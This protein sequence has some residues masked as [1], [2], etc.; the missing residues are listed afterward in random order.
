M[1]TTLTDGIS[2]E[3]MAA[4]SALF[5]KDAPKEVLVYVEGIDDKPFWGNILQP[6]ERQ[7]NVRFSIQTPAKGKKFA[8]KQKGGLGV[9]LIICVDSDYDYLLQGATETSRKVNSSSYVFQTYAYSIENMQCYSGGLQTI[10][11]ALAES[12]ENVV[13]FEDLMEKY[14]GIIY[15]LFLWS[16]YFYKKET[17]DFFPISQ[18]HEAIQV[19]IK[20]SS[21]SLAAQLTD[22]L[23]KLE[24][25]VKKKVHALES[26]FPTET[27]YVEELPESLKALDVTQSNAYLFAQGHAIKN[28]TLRFLAI[29]VKYLKNKSIQKVR[30]KNRHNNLSVDDMLTD[31]VGYKSCFL[32]QKIENDLNCYIQKLRTITY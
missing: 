15:K 19:C 11:A 21:A 16:F 7:Y 24:D 22:A 3:Y 4:A 5:P 25:S 1:Q 14:S 10:C 28:V 26:R 12:E 32:Y 6:L 30:G 27:V 9:H 20:K 17:P 23:K 2:S 18:F 31:S 29:T 13:D 8:L